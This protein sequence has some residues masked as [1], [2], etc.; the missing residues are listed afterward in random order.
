[1]G[2]IAPRLTDAFIERQMFKQQR[3][4]DLSQ[5]REGS[6][7]RPQRDG[8]EHGLPRGRVIQSSVYTKAALSDAMRALP[9]IVAGLV[10]AAGV[11]VSSRAWKASD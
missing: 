2:R 9:F 6:L 3:R 8:R 10:F 5:P 7:D 11:R 1:M 4:F